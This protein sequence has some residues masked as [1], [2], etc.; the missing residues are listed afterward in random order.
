MKK[1]WQ[2]YL[3]IF[4]LALNLGTAGALAYHYYQ[5]RRQADFKMVPP[6]PLRELWNLTKLD[7]A[8]QE[9]IQSMLP[10]H[11]RLLSETTQ[12]LAEKRQ[13]LFSLIASESPS[14]SAMQA[15]VREISSFQERLE[16]EIVQF[17]LEVKQHLKPEQQT[18]FLSVVEGRLCR[19]R[20]GG[21]HQFGHGRGRGAGSGP[22]IPPRN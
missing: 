20:G 11:R 19:S 18:A 6:M 4:S 14:R 5:E 21:G 13:E 2:T 3:L 7:P 15:K 10:E 16:Q 12:E 1:G 8:Q 17:L 22:H 9:A